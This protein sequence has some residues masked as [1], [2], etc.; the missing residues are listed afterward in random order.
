MPG[1]AI[2]AALAD[3]LAQ[4]PDWTNPPATRPTQGQDLA[5]PDW[6]S[7]NWQ[8][9]STLIDLVAPLAPDVTSPGFEGNRTLL[10]QPVSFEVRFVPRRSPRNWVPALPGVVEIVSDRA[11]NGLNIAKAYLGDDLVVQVEVDPKNP[12]TQVTRLRGNRSLVSTIPARAIETVSNTEFITSEIFQQVFRGEGNPPYL[13]QV[14]TTT[15]Y[16]YQQPDP[17]QRP[18]QHPD[19][20]QKPEQSQPTILANQ[21]TAVYLS[22]QDENYFKAVQRPI[23]L[24]RYRLELHR[25]GDSSGSEDSAG[26]VTEA[27]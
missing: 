13:N 24:Y 19:Q 15:A 21:V 20:H 3:R 26:T 4:Y 16:H 6:F 8:A 18:D 11:F 27:S 9:T 12:N 5:Y 10:N 23:A 2:A 22:P 25:A 14:E 1:G 17:D 7:G